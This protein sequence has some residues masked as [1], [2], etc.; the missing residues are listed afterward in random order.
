[1][2]ITRH[3]TRHVT[4]RLLAAAALLLA[5]CGGSGGTT[6]GT[7]GG[8]DFVPFFTAV[9]TTPAEGTTPASLAGVSF[10]NQFPDDPA[11]FAGLLGP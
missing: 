2:H 9:F 7:P 11:T 3:V 8:T 4:R 1:M 5:A 10:A 6:T